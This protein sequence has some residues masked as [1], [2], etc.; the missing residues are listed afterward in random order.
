MTV[1]RLRALLGDIG[2]PTTALE[3]AEIL[4]L[5]AHMSSEPAIEPVAGPVGKQRVA[6][7]DRPAPEAST[8]ALATP[9]SE[10]VPPAR[11]RYELHPSP[12]EAPD[13]RGV[14]EVLLPTAPMLDHPLAIQRALRPLKRRVPT[15]TAVTLDEEASAARIAGQPRGT[16]PWVPVLAA[17]QERWLSLLLVVDT[18][19]SMRLW[20]P[21]ARELH[22][23]LIRVGAFRD[24]RVCYL[25]GP[26]VAAFP[27]APS[28]DAATSLDP[29]GR[30][31]VLVLSDCSGPHWWDGRAGRSLAVWARH[32]P[33][34]IL[35]PLAERLWRR[36][37]A[38]TVPGPATAVRPCP[39]N[40]ALRF[41][42]YD[43]DVTHGGVPVP[44]LE[45][46]P[47]W[48][49]DWAH[50]VSGAG[51]AKP[52]AMTYVGDRRSQL[53][54]VAGERALPIRERVRRFQ[55]TASPQAARLAAYAA[56]SFPA[57]PVLR[58]IQQR[59]LGA[60][61]PGQLA[62]VLLSGLLR[63]TDLSAEA[64]DFVSGAREEL[65]S[66]LPRSES[67]HTADVL[68]QVSEEI[69]RRAG[70]VGEM[71]RA[72][73]PVPDERGGRGLA[74]DSRR[75]GLV[76]P[77]ALHI[78]RPSAQAPLAEP[79]GTGT[80]ARNGPD[81][82]A[83]IRVPDETGAS[84]LGGISAVA[85]SPDGTILATGR[86][87]GVVRLWD[88]VT[89]VVIRDFGGVAGGVAA[90]AWSPDGSV[91]A[92]GGGSG[93]VRLWD[94]VTGVVIRDFGGVAGGVAAV[95]WSPDGSVLATGGGSGVV[96]LWDPVTGVVIRD[97]GGVA[98]G[99]AAVAWSPDGSVLATGGENGIVR[100][101]GLAPGER[102]NLLHCDT[103]VRALAWSP[104]GRA[105]AT[106]GADGTVRSWGLATGEPNAVLEG[107]GGVVLTVAWNP[108]GLALAAGGT[109]HT[110]RVWRPG[111][112]ETVRAPHGH[113]GPVRA[114]AW[115]FD[116]RTLA[117]GGDDGIVRLWDPGP[118][119]DL[120]YLSYS[121]SDENWASWL[122]WEL[123]AAGF[124]TRLQAWD[125]TPGTNFVDFMDRGVSEATLVLAVLS[126]KYLRSAYGRMEAQAAL[127][128][129]PGDPDQKL[130]TVRV[131]D[132]QVDG[133]LAGVTWVDLVGVGDPGQARSLVLTR[134]RRTLRGRAERQDLA[135]P[136][137]RLTL[138]P[139]P[140]P[141]GDRRV[142][143]TPVFPPADPS[144]GKHR[145]PRGT[146]TVL[147]VTGPRFG[148]DLGQEMSAEELPSRIWDEVIQMEDGGAPWPDLLVVTGNLTASGTRREFAEALAFLTGLRTLFGLEPERL[149]VVPG[150]NDVTRAASHAYFASCE[151]DDVLPRPPYWPKWRHYAG[152][153]QELY[154]GLDTLV[155]DSVQPWTLF[156][157]PDLKVVVAGINSTMAISHLADDQYGLVGEAQ[158]AWFAERVRVFEG[159]G[160]LRLGAL[161]HSLAL[162]GPDQLADQ[163]VVE[164][165]L[166]GRLNAVLQDSGPDFEPGILPSGALCLP[167]SAGGHQLL[168]FT[169][170]GL[171][172]WRGDGE[173]EPI[174]RSWVS[175]QGAFSASAPE[176]SPRPETAPAAVETADRVPEQAEVL[177][178][179]IAEVCETR[180]Q[181]ARIRRS[182]GNPPRLLVTYRENDFDRQL[183]VGAIVGEPT[184]VD[185]DAFLR[186]VD[187]GGAAPGSE[188]V[189]AG[190][191]PP[192]PLREYAMRR[193][194]R[195]RS[196]TE[197]QGLMD[198]SEY[199]A[200][201]AA[202][203][204]VDAA[205][206]PWLYVGQR[207][208]DLD[209]PER[210]VRD[211]LA[212]ELV[213]LLNGDQGRFLLVL[214]D[215]GRG[216]TFLLREVVRRMA[217]ETPHLIP[218]L[219]ELRSLDMAHSLEGLVAAH[220][221]GHG[222]DV[223]D[224]K[225]F[226]YMLRQGRIV[227][228]FDGF[229]ELVTRV[230][231]EGAA[232]HLETLLRAAEDNA[233]IV[234]T[235]RTQHFRSHA[236]V[237][238]ALGERVG[239]LPQRRVL[240]IED[241]SRDQIRS[242]LINRY[243]DAATA[244]ERLLMLG[245]AGD[246]IGLSHNP[247]MLA[248]IADLGE[249]RLRAIG[250]ARHAISAA[251][252]YQEILS[253]WIHYEQLR[254]DRR[255]TRPGLDATDLWK[256]V[257]TLAIR[258]W[259]TDESLLRVNDLAEVAETLADLAGGRMSAEHATH[260]V[261]ASSLLVRT[262]DGLFGF[263]HPSVT[264]W[265]VARHIA[266]ELGVG[267]AE[268]A[269]S[270]RGL[271]PL[272]VDFLC[273][274]AGS[275]ACLQWAGQTL[276]DP[277]AADVARS[278][279][280]RITDRLNPPPSDHL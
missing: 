32:G 67:W 104:D 182:T 43:G 92:T 84:R 168:E 26:G 280:L 279:A 52:V 201:Q 127:R 246:L 241:F 157:V 252:L 13:G 80:G 133:P 59:I 96:R 254:V 215:F 231:Y 125:F 179:Q 216:K 74:S 132:C 220:L 242:Y 95:A 177:L 41:S 128:A 50:L 202:R 207:F 163:A 172:R 144:R 19:P 102:E 193:G 140:Q 56:V 197:F 190:P 243:G 255:G 58:L 130:V 217:A 266:A 223:I 51:G 277:T 5:A 237:L 219:I 108:A 146:V 149:V 91:L 79:S 47:G 122:A 189:Y 176:T 169:A 117:T 196:L 138:P 76:S 221:A 158:A 267:T 129:A 251:G 152:L 25:S 165:L 250:Q 57:L 273:D 6:E 208:R 258:L 232:D 48:F 276:A 90:V 73:V 256:A 170:D 261:G 9:V 260:T 167:A 259:E 162:G 233:K 10:A 272:T 203:L 225:A 44:V 200:G 164:T 83:G 214:G 63:P 181:G 213:D 21:L 186:Q 85:F 107:D 65:L 143:R 2:P 109:G 87:S 263:I 49:A 247:R 66:T 180:F 218:I 234:V 136:A 1:D 178:Q 159:D 81:L 227:L 98:G 278:N 137:E 257:E 244:D 160:W 188:L 60:G 248:F 34:A 119:D 7:Q 46:A 268:P 35:Q 230:T 8:D 183:W 22:E 134:I 77:E 155:F 245:A 64:Y 11:S 71:F 110:V 265:L 116:G 145:A 240:S 23:T 209:R 36:T 15:R 264:E 88:P 38:P 4:W 271:S 93:V 192:R 115:S 29:S 100:L 123:E 97:F 120:I 62:E 68:E 78:L 17:G 135:V 111:T 114:V 24:L 113:T 54:T 75:F 229:D 124:S 161:N 184:A 198:L 118:V 141:A 156:A 205:Y 16:R 69:E 236:Q 210:G 194:V 211:D 275:R 33:T 262:D 249:D 173:P 86:Q 151:A 147:H 274:M 226:R 148:A 42:A 185:V 53:S 199:V 31:V 30:L 224:L 222:Q 103:S 126:E 228:F 154:Q 89:G 171:I 269:L 121:P 174:G 235:S 99:V 55:A 70:A 270:R 195:V 94:P 131:E 82:P 12:I 105:L 139:S 187:A 3:V 191:A 37:A 204:E 14:A 142:R 72:C 40:P 166:G 150:A 206:P 212:G 28:R 175:A 153:F 45:C 39:P 253:S 20:Q 106:G 18:G 101:F 239:L 61:R 27:G 238:T 112:G